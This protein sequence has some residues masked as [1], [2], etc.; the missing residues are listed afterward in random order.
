MW[1]RFVLVN[2]LFVRQ[3]ALLAAFAMT[4]GVA[5]LALKNSH[6]EQSGIVAGG[7]ITIATLALKGLLDTFDREK[8]E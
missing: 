3:I 5:V 4:L 7:C 1:R 2:I 6:L 8:E